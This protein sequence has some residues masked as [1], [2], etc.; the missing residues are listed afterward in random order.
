VPAYVYEC[1]EHGQFEVVK[2]MAD[3]GREE[4][5]P[6]KV[7]PGAVAL[8][9]GDSVVCT[10]LTHRV[11]T[12]SALHTQGSSGDGYFFNKKSGLRSKKR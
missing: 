5:C 1:P 10:R 7:V 4:A 3:S 12:P 8:K 9:I 2:P 6:L 11:Y